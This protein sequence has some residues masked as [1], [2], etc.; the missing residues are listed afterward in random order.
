MR[1]KCLKLLIGI[2]FLAA[3]LLSGCASGSTASSSAI[4]PEG[5]ETDSTGT[6]DVESEETAGDDAPTEK[7]ESTNKEDKSAKPSFNKKSER[8]T[9]SN[10]GVTA[11]N[12]DD[13]SGDSTALSEGDD[14]FSEMEGDWKYI[15]Y[16]YFSYDTE[17]SGDA[18]VSPYYPIGEYGE[19]GEEGE[20]SIY[21]DDGTF[22]ADYVMSAMGTESYNGLT[23]TQPREEEGKPAATLS[24][25]RSDSIRHELLLE[26][27]DI[28]VLSKIYDSGSY[29]YSYTFA[30]NGSDI[31][32]HFEDAQYLDTVTVSNIDEFAAA[33]N[34]RTKIVL[35]EGTFNFSDLT[36]DDLSSVF[37]YTKYYDAIEDLRIQ[38]IYNLGIFA[39]DGA[40]VTI[41]TEDSYGQPLA[42]DNCNQ[43]TISGITAGHEV[44]KGYCTGSVIYANLTDNL[45]I[46][47]CDLYGSGTYG[48]EARTCY[49]INVTDT[50]I[51]DCTYGIVN[52]YNSSDV[53]FNNCEMTENEGFDMIAM[54][55]CW[56]V[57][58]RDCQVT[59][60]AGSESLVTTFINV[61]DSSATA[62]RSCTFRNNTYNAFLND[63]AETDGDSAVEFEECDISGPMG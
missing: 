1:L 4:E 12:E 22:Y 2:P 56:S 8:S 30:R 53:L 32:D 35:K 13:A 62:F 38:G 63:E 6:A 31:L 20:L 23:L 16:Q 3:L 51:H 21:E 5:A 24:A 49:N 59:D 55:G 42:F 43:I 41:V 7:T 36:E 34:N 25:R 57:E 33:I 60:N 29:W 19:Y 47:N 28:I 52:L 39:E 50:V 14:T 48:L 54:S 10:T 58:F 18:Y 40:D 44:E 61:H 15:G 27:D 11:E 17:S 46:A 9:V 37:S 26:S 45:T